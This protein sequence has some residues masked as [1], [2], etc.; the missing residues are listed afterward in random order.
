MSK[1]W[2]GIM[3]QVLVKKGRA[4][5]EEIPT[6]RVSDNGVLVK[7]M[8]SCISAGTEMTEVNESGKSMI[9]KAYEQPEKIRKALNLLKDKGIGGVLGKVK[10]MEEGKPT[11]YSASGIIIGIGKNIRDLKAGDRVACSGA[12]CANHAEFIDVPRNLVM[13]MPGELSFEEASTVALGGIAFQGVRRAEAKIGE[14]IVV[15]GLGIIG[16]LTVQLLNLC[17][18]RVIGIDIDER[19]LQIAGVSDCEALINSKEKNVVKEVENITEGK[20]VDAVII[21]A[22]SNSDE[23]LSQAFKL[24]RR[25]G[26][27]VLVGVVG[28]VYKR[29]DMYAKELDFLI[30]T[31]YG[32]G[33]YDPVYEEQGIDYPYAYVRWTENRN[34]EEYLKLASEKKLK[35]NCLIEKI[36]EI[37]EAASAYEILKSTENKPLIVLLKYDETGLDNLKNAVYFSPANIPREGL[38]NVAVIGAGSFAKSMHLPNLQKLSNLY[39]IYA[40]MSRRGTNARAIAAQYGASYATT[41]YNEILNDPKV[42]M[43]MICTRHNLH[44]E[45][46]IKAMKSGKAV[47]VEKPMALTEEELKEVLET[48]EETKVPYTVGFNR[49]FSK[50]AEEAKH[51][52]K[53]RVN[54]IIIN[55]IMNAGYVPLD[56][57]VHTNEGG[58]RIIGEG[59]HIFDLFNFFTESR[60][61]NISI[62]C[63][64]PK[65]KNLSTRDN[66]VVSV[67]YEDGSLCTLT[68]TSIGSSEFDKEFCQIFYDGKIIIIEDYKRL[69]CFGVNHAALESNLPD[70][71]QY[72]ELLAFASTIKGDE[73]TAIPLWQLEQ[74]TRLA[75][76][77]DKEMSLN[78]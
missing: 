28:S 31:S 16:Q 57:W 44:A 17:G 75:L 30:S 24:C 11:G 62:N 26:R 13:K 56:S 60:V 12:G 73:N 40:I 65:T 32:P 46:A 47:F 18:C 4:Y 41:D 8:Y 35:L 25:K 67:K 70:K 61:L 39:N 69:K 64:E 36:Y 14:I 1:I 9:K 23:I 55:Y 33:R 63:M 5:L 29:E 76:V 42:D 50:Y 6:P 2:E 3:K 72:E 37:N 59:C 45:M 49:R 15:V 34:M 52:I 20:G 58:G 53:D 51:M 48:L 19:R 54:P 78:C 66:V 27:V 38:I 22:A 21:T 77:T 68:Y 74:A 7:V 43:V 71:G 10:E